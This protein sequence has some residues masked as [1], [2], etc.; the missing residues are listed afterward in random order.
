MKTVTVKV[1]ITD[2]NYSAIVEELD[3]FV[4]TADT[5]PE[6]KKEVAEGVEFHLEGMREDNDPIP[7]IFQGEFEFK[8]KWS[9]ESLLNYYQGIFTNAALERITGINQK[10]LWHYA[11]G[12]KEPRPDT[13]EKINSALHKLGEELLT[14]EL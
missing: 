10:Q 9:T 12:Q 11:H 3:G 2:N 13:K 1:G 14:V 5:F 8:Y 6:L 7:E 4:C